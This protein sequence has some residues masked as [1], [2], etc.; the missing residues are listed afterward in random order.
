MR[1]QSRVLM[2]CP[3][4]LSNELIAEYFQVSPFRCSV[5]AS[6]R[7]LKITQ[8]D[9]LIQLRRSPESHVVLVW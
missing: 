8:P 4:T 6:V 7:K 2:P 9:E 5:V 1:M 3:M